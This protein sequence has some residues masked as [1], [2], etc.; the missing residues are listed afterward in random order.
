[1]RAYITLLSNKRYILG[2]IALNRMLR[3]VKS[4]YPLYCALSSDVEETV[5]SKLES[6]GICCIRLKNHIETSYRISGENCYAHWNNTF[7]KLQIW[8]LTQFEKLVFLDSDLL[9]MD[10]I[11]A[12]FG[13]APFSGVCAG[14]SWPGNE[15]WRGI[16]S[17]VMVVKP[18]IEV[19]RKLLELVP[20]VAEKYKQANRL[21]G[22]Q[23]ILQYYLTE[24]WDETPSLQLD[25]GYNIFADFLNH[26]IKNL[27][28][29][30][31]EKGKNK[32]YVVHFIG[33]TKPWM[34][35]SLRERYW[36]LKKMIWN[37]YY[38]IARHKFLQYLQKENLV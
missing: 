29:S 36:L 9:I 5:V 35:L 38:I 27:G 2:V 21:M 32:I 25:E 14:K 34:K 24:K 31:N 33:R 18:D 7:D 23:D 4:Q 28:Y 12:L 37:P 30:W 3:T 13:H 10:N 22:D 20:I 6:D 17:G 15:N 16:N 19:K 8:G 1:M 11:D 26:Y